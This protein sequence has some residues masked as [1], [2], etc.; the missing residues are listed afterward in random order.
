MLLIERY[1]DSIHHTLLSENQ[2][3]CLQYLG[4]LKVF[5]LNLP[6]CIT[7]YKVSPALKGSDMAECLHMMWK[8]HGVIITT[9]D[10]V[11]MATLN[12]GHPFQ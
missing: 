1:I 12:R 7:C 2:S 5:L 4:G 8:S 9:V 10:T 6:T 3:N 11:A